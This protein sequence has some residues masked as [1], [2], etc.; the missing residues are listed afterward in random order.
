[1][2]T[3]TPGPGPAHDAVDA[4]TD[5]WAA[6]R[7]DLDTVPMAVFGRIYRLSNAMRG[8]V[9]KAYAPYGLAL[10]EFDVLATLRRSGE[11]YTLSPRELT[12]TLMITTG[13]MTGRLDK[14]EKAGL[15]TRSP[16]P[17]D[18]RGLRVTLTERGREL[19]DE[20]VAAG[21]AQQRAALE[22]ALSEEEAAQ[23]AGLL[24][25]LLATTA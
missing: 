2:D 14:L 21:L 19:V 7:P 24:R 12:A 16:D 11:P 15:V 5:Q 4:I 1:M 18:R 13:G 17:H 6:V 22:G 25:K 3:K 9:D 20:S 10:G 8:K 23:L